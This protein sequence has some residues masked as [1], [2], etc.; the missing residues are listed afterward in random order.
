VQETEE[1]GSSDKYVHW[2][3]YG[4]GWSVRERAERLEF[5]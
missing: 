2:N 5:M 3:R 4:Y 1:E